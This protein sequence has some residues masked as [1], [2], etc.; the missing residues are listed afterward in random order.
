MGKNV[1][2]FLI[3]SDAIKSIPQ[4]HGAFYLMVKYPGVSLVDHLQCRRCGFDP[5]IR[6]IPGRQEMATHSSILVWRTQTRQRSLVGYSPWGLEK[7]RHNC[8]TK[9]QQKYAGTEG[10]R[11]QSSSECWL[12]EN[13]TWLQ[14][15]TS[16]SRLV[17]M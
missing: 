2:P 3:F 8:V 6:K 11:V 15:H 7:I 10:S 1:Q 17:K 9:Q 4:T 13:L 12:I 14:W 16:S 5:W